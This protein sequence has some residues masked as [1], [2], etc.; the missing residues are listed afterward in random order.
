MRALALNGQLPSTL[1]LVET[2][3]R[4]CAWLKSAGY[5]RNELP[6]RCTTRRHLQAFLSGAAVN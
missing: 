4:I 5:A 6:S 1:R 2:H 3:R